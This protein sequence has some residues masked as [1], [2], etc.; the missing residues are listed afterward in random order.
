[1]QRET[2]LGFNDLSGVE[3]LLY[4]AP[5][6]DYYPAT[7]LALIFVSGELR[8]GAMS[9]GPLALKLRCMYEGKVVQVA[10]V[11]N[12]I[13]ERLRET[14]T[15]LPVTC[16]FDDIPFIR[17]RY[18]FNLSETRSHNAHARVLW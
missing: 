1:M 13:E 4:D 6:V 12:S 15:T 18:T 7:V 11:N 8:R 2:S 5:T 9:C 10:M 17:R 16:R 14:V 3:N